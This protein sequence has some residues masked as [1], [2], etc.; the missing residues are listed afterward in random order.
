[1][2]ALSGWQ[3]VTAQDGLS[4]WSKPADPT[5]ACAV[6]PVR[7]YWFL[8]DNSSQTV[9]EDGTAVFNLSLLPF[10]G[11][12]GT[13]TLHFD[14][15]REVPGLAAKMTVRSVPL[16]GTSQL[17]VT[18]ALT[19]APGT[20]PITFYANSGSRTR[21]VTAFLVVPQ[22]SVRLSTLGL[23]FGTRKAKTSSPVHSFT[24][25]NFGKKTLSLAAIT[26]SG[27]KDY[28]ET[29]NCGAVLSAGETCTVSVTFT[30]KAAGP[31]NGIL[32]ITDGDLTGPQ[33]VTLTGSGS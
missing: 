7:D 10:G 28:T 27:A 12:T 15:I 14:G 6:A 13:A 11:L 2:H 17:L 33:I 1:M 31:R 25:T 8:V 21:S 19:A 30:P 26:F 16:T 4:N 9:A 29:H 22:T 20:Y 23:D 32:T 18:A 24:I 3:S 5:S